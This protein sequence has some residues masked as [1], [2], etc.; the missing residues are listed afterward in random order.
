MGEK[1]ALQRLKIYQ[2][3]SAYMTDL[4][5]LM[6]SALE[7]GNGHHHR[8]EW[9]GGYPHAHRAQHKLLDCV[10]T[11]HGKNANECAKAAATIYT[12]KYGFQHYY[13]TFLEEQGQTYK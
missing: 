3:E 12:K 2:A 10:Q 6:V 8:E 11:K 13:R 7:I 4:S 9:Q 1:T 5:R